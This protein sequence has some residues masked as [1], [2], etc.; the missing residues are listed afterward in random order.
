VFTN[1][2]AQATNSRAKVQTAIQAKA[3]APVC[4]ASP[5]VPV[6]DDRAL[7]D[8]DAAPAIARTSRRA[9]LLGLAPSRRLIAARRG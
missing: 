9:P 6:L 8:R 2:T 4:T 1:A 3:S 7:A 5:A